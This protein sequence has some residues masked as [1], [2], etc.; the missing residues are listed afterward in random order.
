MPGE[1]ALPTSKIAVVIPAYK[2]SK[3]ILSVISGLNAGVELIYVIDDA[4]PEN[5]GELVAKSVA[6][7]R[8]KVITHEKNQGVGGAMVTGYKAALDDEATIIIKVDGDGQMDPKDIPTLVRPILEGRADYAKGNRFDSFED[9][10]QMPKL[11][12]LGNAALSL[13]SK[14]S[15]GYWNI[16]DPTNGF[17]AIH[18]TV[19]KRIDLDKLQKRFFFESDLLFRLSL[20]RAVVKDVALP[21]RYGDEVSNLRIWKVIR[22]FPARHFVNHLKRI[23]YLYYLREWSVASIELPSGLLL[24]AGGLSFGA[25]KWIESMSTGLPTNAGSVMI[26]AVS[27]ILGFQLLLAFISYDV[28]SEPKSPRQL[29]S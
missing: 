3:H 28:S 6:D 14:V 1:V 8:V 21:A 23:F 20:L 26:S 10:Q 4:C 7:A 29:E 15:T 27:L 18:A 12:I 9:L 2:V 25:S 13:M 11:R 22:E 24:C 17:T 16:T 19:L 5:S